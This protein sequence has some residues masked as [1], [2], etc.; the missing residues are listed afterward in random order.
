MWV[1]N[2]CQAYNEDYEDECIYCGKG[3]QSSKRRLLPDS[4]KKSVRLGIFILFAFLVPPVIGFYSFMNGIDM[5]ALGIVVVGIMNQIVISTL[6]L[7]TYFKTSKLTLAILKFSLV[8]VVLTNSFD[9]L[10]SEASVLGEGTILEFF[11]PIASLPSYLLAG[12]DIN[13]FRSEYGLI[14]EY[15]TI[16]GICLLIGAIIGLRLR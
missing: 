7:I 11:T 12:L 14:F 3:K 5:G 6:A 1:C 15:V 4:S 10:L 16:M 2:Y 9:N 8:G 13:I